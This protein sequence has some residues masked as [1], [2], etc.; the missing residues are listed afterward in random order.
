M[1]ASGAKY[2]R[3]T[4]N[5]KSSDKN[6]AHNDNSVDFIYALCFPI[7]PCSRC[8]CWF[9]SYNMKLSNILSR[10]GIMLTRMTLREPLFLLKSLRI[11]GL[12]QDL[13]LSPRLQQ[14]WFQKWLLTW[15][16]LHQRRQPLLQS[17][18]SQLWV[19]FNEQLMKEFDEFI[20]R[21]G[22][23]KRNVGKGN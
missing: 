16:Q 4:V 7:N 13:R 8:E 21:G 23:G 5:G 6:L 19:F 18:Q 1:L 17:Q 22:K 11:Q 20:N 9:S 15:L 10:A 12:D 3:F 14:K 2:K